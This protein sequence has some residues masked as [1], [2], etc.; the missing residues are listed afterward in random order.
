MARTAPTTYRG[1]SI[2]QENNGTFSLFR[3]GYVA[4][5]FK[6]VEAAK[7]NADWRLD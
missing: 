7:R 2:E 3:F 1:F 4:G 6:S 5:G